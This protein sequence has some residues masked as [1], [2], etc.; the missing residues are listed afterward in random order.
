MRLPTKSGILTSKRRTGVTRLSKKHTPWLAI[1]LLASPFSF[2]SAAAQDAEAGEVIRLELEQPQLNC[3]APVLRL[4]ATDRATLQDFY[5]QQAFAPVWRRGSR[6]ERLVEQLE[7]LA[8]DG[9]DPHGYQAAT[10]RRL[11]QSRAE[12]QSPCTDVLASHA[13]LQ[14]LQHLSWGRLDAA[15]VEPI[16]HSPR[17]P[18]PVRPVAP[19]PFAVSGLDD[20][21]GAFAQ[22]RPQFELYRKLRSTWSEVRRQ[23]LPQWQ[24]VPGGPLLRPG[25]HDPRVLALAQR[26]ASEGFLSE[27]AVEAR[28]QNPDIDRYDPLL[29]DAV[30]AYQRAHLLKDDGIVGP[31]TLTELNVS[32]AARRDQLRVNLERLRWLAREA[33]PTM[34]LVDIAGAKISYYQNGQRRWQAR[35]QVGRA[36]RQTPL[37][38]SRI[39]H[40]TI[41][42]TWTVPPTI[43]REDKLP[44]IRRD[45]GYL[46]KNRIRVLDPAGNQLDPHQIDWSN[47]PGILLRQDAGPDSALGVV[48]IR[49]PNPFS[50][51]LHDTPNQ[52]LFDKLPRVFSSGCVRVEQVAELLDFL[53]ADAT[54]A[55]RARIATIQAS[56]TT[57]DVNLPRPVTI[58]LAYWTVE[59]GDDGRLH[60]RPDLYHRDAALLTALEQAE[61]R[62]G[63][64][65]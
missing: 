8:D 40:L 34:V 27:A 20:L 31:A 2:S 22:A 53:L 26:L 24:R 19:P 39:S 63:V 12:R 6:L 47:P 60:Y 44:E 9:L 56:G 4:S 36:E 32:P 38:K 18:A 58:L 37:L 5:Q 43:F 54:P 35:T 10:L 15:Q 42:P 41:N 29:V 23:P 7:Q 55:E 57:K 25:R 65:P 52:H 11:A 14:A 30:E 51:Y 61:R 48:A 17:T 49:F 1:L 62:L 64:V 28:A 50:V 21:A 16:W 45:I 3:A 59:V 13:Y 33:E 46:S